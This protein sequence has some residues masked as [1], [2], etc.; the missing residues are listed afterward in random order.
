MVK[1]KIQIDYSVSSSN[2][3]KRKRDFSDDNTSRT[4]KKLKMGN[5]DKIKLFS[6]NK[7]IYTIGNVVHFTASINQHT[8]EKTIRKITKII[9]LNDSKYKDTNEKLEIAYI[10]DSGGGCVTSTLKFID[11]INMARQKHPY[12]VFTSII[13]GLV[14]SAGTIMCICA[15]NRYMT[16]YAFAMVHELSSG[17]YGSYQHLVSHSKFLKSLHETLISIYLK[18]TKLTKKKL[19]SLLLEETWFDSKGYLKAGFVTK[20]L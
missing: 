11:F 19:E 6:K 7:Q 4:S 9:N 20:I 16:E 17:N 14:A 15:D 5:K 13:T 1:D 10:V 12:L 8:I 18:N 2:S 3:G